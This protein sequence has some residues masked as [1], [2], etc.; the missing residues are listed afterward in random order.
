MSKVTPH[1]RLLGDEEYAAL[2]VRPGLQELF[3]T[4][5]LSEK[6]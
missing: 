3:R 1:I 2:F 4:K 6:A 5:A